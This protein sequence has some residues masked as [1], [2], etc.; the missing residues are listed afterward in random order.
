[1]DMVTQIISKLTEVILVFLKSLKEDELKWFIKFQNHLIDEVRDFFASWLK[2]YS[3]LSEHLQW[4]KQAY[5]KRGIEIDLGDLH[6]PQKPKGEYWPLLVA[7]EISE[8]VLIEIIEEAMVHVREKEAPDEKIEDPVVW[9]EKGALDLLIN[10]PRPDKPYVLWFKSIPNASDDPDF[11]GKLFD[12]PTQEQCMTAKERL[13]AEI[14]Y[15][16][17]LSPKQHLDFRGRTICS[18]F[19]SDGRVIIIDY[20]SPAKDKS[21]QDRKA[22]MRIQLIDPK[23]LPD[24]SWGYRVVFY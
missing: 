2:P 17:F 7:P 15:F 10:P 18:S 20:Y 11:T 3:Q 21:L 16:C 1:M 6:I 5:L 24:K 9:I 23:L 4:W 12:K 13:L 8:N 22:Y 14:A 19:V